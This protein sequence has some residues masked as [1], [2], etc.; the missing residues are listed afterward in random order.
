LKCFGVT[1]VRICLIYRLIFHA[2]RIVLLEISSEGRLSSSLNSSW[3]GA[4]GCF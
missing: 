4:F 3:F 2:K 1:F